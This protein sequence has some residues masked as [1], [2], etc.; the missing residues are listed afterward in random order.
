MLLAFKQFR[1]QFHTA[2]MS[3]LLV[4]RILEKNPCEMGVK[5][6]GEMKNLII[7]QI[8]LVANF[9]GASRNRLMKRDL[10]YFKLQRLGKKLV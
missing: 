5:Q 3:E 4:K 7:E 10:K 1:N 2:K 6:S 9:I 8:E